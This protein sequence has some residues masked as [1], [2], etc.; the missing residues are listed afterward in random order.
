MCGL[1]T[2]PSDAIDLIPGFLKNEKITK[3]IWKLQEQY[4]ALAPQSDDN[5]HFPPN[6]QPVIFHVKDI[7][8][9]LHWL[10][11]WT[12]GGFFRNEESNPVFS[13]GQVSNL[14][15]YA[16]E[17]LAV[18]GPRDDVVF[19]IRGYGTVAFDF[20]REKFWTSGRLFVVDGKLNVII[21]TFQ[22][23]KDKGIRLAEGAHGILDNTADIHFS[24]GNRAQVTKMPGRIVN[25]TGVELHREGG[26]IRPDWVEIDVPLAV[27]AY[28]G[29]IIP[30]DERK[31]ETKIKTEAAKLTLE[32]RVMREEMA[33]MRKQLDDLKHAGGVTQR[34]LEERLATLKDLKDQD[35]I[36]AD[37]YQRR[38]NEILQEI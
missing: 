17:A 10:E 28:R 38:R 37:E 34:S 33:R 35:L 36:S 25:T 13:G 1:W 6:D 32:R 29:S 14:A 4:V 3:S 26:R 19:N 22:V 11:L 20:V 7:A 12:E 21:G 9:A 24:H 15:N 18:A 2:T 5:L 8:D 27:A 30:E 31:R 23:K 16:V